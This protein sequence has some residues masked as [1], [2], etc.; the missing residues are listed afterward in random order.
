MM[1]VVGGRCG[2]RRPNKERAQV[3]LLLATDNHRSL[4]PMYKHKYRHKYKHKL[5]NYQNYKLHLHLIGGHG[6]NAKDWVVTECAKIVMYK[7]TK[8][9][10]CTEINCFKINSQS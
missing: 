3:L 7:T 9:V 1:L 5:Y 4:Y 2:N 8:R 10:H 6:Q